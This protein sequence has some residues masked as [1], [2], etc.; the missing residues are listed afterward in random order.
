MVRE[1]GKWVP[2]EKFAQRKGISKTTVYGRIRRGEIIKRT[3]GGRVE[4]FVVGEDVE[5]F[6]DVE[7]SP[8]GEGDVM[9]DIELPDGD[10]YGIAAKSLQTLLT[11]HKEILAEKHRMLE[12][13]EA[14][15]ASR[16]EKSA[17]LE[18]AL[19]ERDEKLADKA[20]EVRRLRSA[21]R[22]AEETAER[23]EK[24]L[25]ET[26]KTLRQMDDLTQ[27]SE[28]DWNRMKELLE[29]KDKLLEAKDE[30]IKGMESAVG[31]KEEVLGVTD[32]RIEELK[33]ALGEMRALLNEK[34][35]I[36]RKFEAEPGDLDGKLAQRDQAI[37]ELGMYV[38]TLEQQ[39]DSVSKARE[40]TG[41]SEEAMPTTTLIQDQLE[42][43]MA[44]EDAHKYLDDREAIPPEEG[45]A[46]EE[47]EL[48]K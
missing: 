33:N 14:E 9:N 18:S 7:S 39:L 43:L 13:W 41:F 5:L 10:D 34:E 11:M 27:G 37:E 25:E 16:E 30:I 48:E 45:E 15:L 19:S 23:L 1:A 24:E 2:L 21:V 38:K 8:I 36:I 42:Y 31:Q 12:E 3:V 32:D 4:V 6:E 17:Q 22:K 20:V 28:R 44:G 29:E 26:R 46:A 40:L 47:G 35:E